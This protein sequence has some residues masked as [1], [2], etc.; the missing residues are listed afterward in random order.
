MRSPKPGSQFR[1]VAIVAAYNEA[2][3]I[4]PVIAHLVEQGIEVYLIDN[5]STDG[6]AEQA[7]AWLG[8]GLL[9]IEVSP[10]E[11]P[12]AGAPPAFDWAA[13]LRRKEEIANA[14][15]ADW[16]L[17]HDADEFR[18]SP[19]PGT[20]LKDGI[21]WVDRLGFNCIDFRVLNFPPVDDGFPP[22]GDPREYFTRWE[23]PI[24]HDTVQLKCWKAGPAPVSLAA[25]GG[26][27][28]RFRGRRIFPIKFL[29]RHY[30]IRSQAHGRRKVFDERKERFLEE[31]RKKGWHVHYDRIT[32]PSHSF[33][34]DPAK[35]TP[36]D[37]DQIRFELM[38]HSDLLRVAQGE[39]EASR[40]EIEALGAR[41]DDLDRHVANLEEDRVRL[42]EYVASLQ[43][44]GENRSAQAAELDRL[45]R[46]KEER[47][48]ALAGAAKSAE[49]ERDL[50]EDEIRRLGE[51]LS[52]R[53][54][55]VANL[56]SAQTE[57]EAYV[58]SLASGSADSLARES[59]ARKK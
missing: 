12:P 42:R 49:D 34:A 2:D 9:E 36:F 7:R 58:A 52:D 46:E 8:K 15:R 6:T 56:E 24:V 39:I 32:D 47:I 57:M 22:G 11:P 21:R 59:G 16:F 26:H 20:S 44:D 37:P 53:R 41:R 25:S 18:E 51:W 17:H 40:R 33:L 3:L 14:I 31:E 48:A 43:A 28:A 4:S 30:P 54:R 45:L 27:E 55:H 1:V 5:R 35:L 38:L 29:L 13:I 10:A 19:W 50:L 23:E